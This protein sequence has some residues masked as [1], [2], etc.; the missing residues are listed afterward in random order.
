[1]AIK[2]GT[3][4][5]KKVYLASGLGAVMLILLVRFLWQNFGPSPAPPPAP[6]PVVTVARPA[7]TTAVEPGE[8]TAAPTFGHQAAAREQFRKFNDDVYQASFGA[9]FL[10][11][12]VGPATIFLGNLS[13]VAVAVVGGLQVAT[14]QITLGN[15]QAFIQYVRQFNNP[16]SQLAGIYN[17]LQSGV[18]SAE[19]VF[20]LIDEPEESPGPEPAPEQPAVPPTRLAPA[21]EPVGAD[22]LAD[23]RARR[24]RQGRPER[25]CLPPR[26]P[27]P[28]L[29]PASELGSARI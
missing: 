22:D 23:R 3:E 21:R 18:A 20:E 14:G 11:G 7:P 24:A 5:K 26:P 1:M 27:V 6:A 2:V 10:S 17:T 29:R 25:R 16:L 15:I 4:D 19:R 12:L 13:Y 9:Q 8:G 28:H